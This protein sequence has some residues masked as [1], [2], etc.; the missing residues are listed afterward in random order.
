LNGPDT[1]GLDV[2]YHW[3]R[4]HWSRGTTGLD[5]DAGD[6]YV[7]DACDHH[8]GILVMLVTSSCWYAGDAGMLVTKL[9]YAGPAWSSS[10]TG[11]QNLAISLSYFPVC[12]IAV[13]FSHCLFQYPCFAFTMID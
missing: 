12:S 1:T 5:V 3:S 9:V 2:G 6:W 11:L 10:Q 8:V 4:Y 13:I 7:G